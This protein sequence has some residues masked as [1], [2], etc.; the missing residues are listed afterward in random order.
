MIERY[1]RPAMK[2]V[3]SDENKFDRW[4]DVE[5]ATCE[6][7]AEMA[8]QVEDSAEVTT[9]SLAYCMGSRPHKRAATSGAGRSAAVSRGSVERR[10]QR[11]HAR[12][13]APAPRSSLPTP[14]RA[15]CAQ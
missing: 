7:W 12:R 11:L 4:L 2:R 15:G 13:L 14:R 1:S 6:A 5:I 9:S 10:Q 8:Q 3:W